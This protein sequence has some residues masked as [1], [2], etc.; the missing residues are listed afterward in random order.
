MLFTRGL[1][2]QTLIW[3]LSLYIGPLEYLYNIAHTNDTLIRR[4]RVAAEARIAETS[5]I[6]PSAE[7]KLRGLG[8]IERGESGERLRRAIVQ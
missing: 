7:E 6:Q 8:E 1:I 2:A 5:G 3:R 4:D